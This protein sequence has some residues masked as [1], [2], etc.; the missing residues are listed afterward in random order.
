MIIQY[1]EF[2]ALVSQIVKQILKLEC[3]R[4][5]TE[6]SR[7]WC[8]TLQLRT[9]LLPSTLVLLFS[10]FQPLKLKLNSTVVSVLCCIFA[11]QEVKEIGKLSSAVPCADQTVRSTTR[12][13]ES[14][15]VAHGKH[16]LKASE[17]LI[18]CS[19]MV[20]ASEAPRKGP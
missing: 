4:S 9:L 12:P 6:T 1:S 20:K 14:Q 15:L 3:V 17:T 18:N 10:Y 5:P 2:L 19:A 13:E 16:R 7:N 11:V 8:Q